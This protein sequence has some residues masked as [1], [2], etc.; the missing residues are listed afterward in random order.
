MPLAGWWQRAGAY[1]I[2]AIIVALAASPATIPI[3]IAM[4][5]RAKPLLDRITA[6]SHAGRAPDLGRFFGDYL[7]AV[8]PLLVWSALAGLVVWVLYD[9]LMLRFKGQ[10]VGMIALGIGV[11]R[12]GDDVQLSWP[13]IGRRVAGQL[14]PNLFFVAASVPV[15]LVVGTIVGGLY[16]V[17]DDLWPLWDRRNQTLHDKLAGTVVVRRR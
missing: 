2:D 14:W 5:S 16:A 13:T 17:L 4:Q 10:T 11:R 9:S 1:L 15:L 7:H 8:G 3:Q 12:T 6:D